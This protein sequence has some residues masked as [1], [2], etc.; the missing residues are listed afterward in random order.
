MAEVY[1][2]IRTLQTRKKPWSFLVCGF[3]WLCLFSC[4]LLSL[5]RALFLLFLGESKV[6][7]CNRQIPLYSLL[8][9]SSSFASL[10]IFKLRILAP[11]IS[12]STPSF[13]STPP[14]SLANSVWSSQGFVLRYRQTDTKQWS[15]VL[16]APNSNSYI[17]MGFSPDGQMVG[18]SAIV[19]LERTAFLHWRDTIS[20]D[21]HRAGSC[22]IQVTYRWGNRTS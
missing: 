14:P 2:K 9:Q 8:Q 22:L 20:E 6:A 3:C 11:E 19:G 4:A 7:N 10:L 16:S 12:P 13:P 15:F 5:L 18:S 17:A 21:N 1:S